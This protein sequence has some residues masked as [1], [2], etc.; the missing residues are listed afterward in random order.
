MYSKPNTQQARNC[1]EDTENII[2]YKQCIVKISRVLTEYV[3]QGKIQKNE[4]DILYIL[5]CS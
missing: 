4:A 3:L 2:P 1:E 5:V